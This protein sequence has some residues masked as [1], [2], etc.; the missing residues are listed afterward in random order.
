LV[1]TEQVI[2]LFIAIFLAGVLLPVALNSIFNA[3]TTSWDTT[4]ATIWPLIATIAVIGVIIGLI[5][6]FGSGG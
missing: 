6:H 1:S 4:T 5:K 3:N 2:T